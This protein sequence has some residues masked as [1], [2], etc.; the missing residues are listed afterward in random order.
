MGRADVEVK[1]LH[2]T[3]MEATLDLFDLA[4]GHSSSSDERESERVILDDAR[5]LG[6]FDGDLLVGTTVA[7]PLQMTIPGTVLGV[8]GVT[9]VS[10]LPTHRRRGILSTLMR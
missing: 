3:Q 5:M 2:A 7:L 1:P 9:G 10:V 4:F 6:A 8:A